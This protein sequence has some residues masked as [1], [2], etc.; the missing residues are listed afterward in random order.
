M[1]RLVVMKRFSFDVGVVYLA[2]AGAD[3]QK[4]LVC[5]G[6]LGFRSAADEP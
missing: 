6:H 4:F 3:F 1:L 5:D 2:A